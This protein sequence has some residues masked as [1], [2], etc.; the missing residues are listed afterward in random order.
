[1]HGRDQRP[2]S[3]RCLHAAADA[4]HC[5]THRPRVLR[6]SPPSSRCARRA[7]RRCWHHVQTAACDELGAA[8]CLSCSCRQHQSNISNSNWP[9][10]RSHAS[11]P[12]E[13]RCPSSRAPTS[14]CQLQ[15]YI[16]GPHKLLAINAHKPLQTVKSRCRR[17]CAV[18]HHSCAR[19]RAFVRSGSERAMCTRPA[20]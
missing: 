17:E 10:T 7:A 2:A 19:L 14:R 12:T 16:H 18:Q 3:I 8:L 11:V 5:P 20:L 1:M 4:L 15:D 13:A 6:P 9:R